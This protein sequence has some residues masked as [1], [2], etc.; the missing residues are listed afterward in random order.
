MITHCF[1]KLFCS[2]GSTHKD[3]H[4]NQRGSFL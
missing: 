1:P 4:R 3:R 2:C